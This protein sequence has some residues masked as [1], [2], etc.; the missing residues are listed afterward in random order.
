MDC[1]QNATVIMGFMPEVP[2]PRGG[3]AH[4]LGKGMFSGKLK[5]PAAGRGLAT[6]G[7]DGCKDL[8]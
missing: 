4:P 8:R 6:L 2:L 5:T 1:A 7:G 3:H